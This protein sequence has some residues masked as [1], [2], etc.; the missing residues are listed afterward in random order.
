MLKVKKKIK[1]TI[2]A[3]KDDRDLTDAE[4]K[5]MIQRYLDALIEEIVEE[6]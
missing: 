6:D 4:R 5:M 2:K 3:I 1:D